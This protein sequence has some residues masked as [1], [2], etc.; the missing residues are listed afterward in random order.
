MQVDGGPILWDGEEENGNPV[1][2]L[3]ELSREICIPGPTRIARKSTNSL[4]VAAAMGFVAEGW[5]EGCLDPP[6]KGPLRTSSCRTWGAS[7]ESGSWHG[8]SDFLGKSL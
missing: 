8:L 2:C 3:A 6:Y 1:E 4:G 7:E 5:S